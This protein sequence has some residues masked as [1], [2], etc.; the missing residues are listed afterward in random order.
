MKG[1]GLK[2]KIFNFKN[3]LRGYFKAINVQCKY[4]MGDID[5][6]N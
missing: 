2:K 5:L 3:L 6:V 4:Q 1:N